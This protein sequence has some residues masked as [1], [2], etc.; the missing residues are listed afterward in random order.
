MGQYYKAV[1]LSEDTKKPVAYGESWDFGSGAKLMEHSY[2]SN[3]FVKAVMLFMQKLGGA[4]LVW[5]GDYDEKLID[6][7]N[8]LYEFVCDNEKNLICI[9]EPA[10]GDYADKFF[11]EGVN[12][13]CNSDKKIAVSTKNIE[14]DSYGFKINP[15]PLLT[16]Q[17]NGQG[18][19]DYWGTEMDKVGT[20]AGDFIFFASE[21]PEG[22]EM[23]EIPFKEK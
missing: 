13:I 10:E 3:R 2:M 23:V 21:L 20:W 22:Y 8:N 9:D 7:K 16:A 17:G 6:G 15:M 1:I 19:G 11:A 14:P 18:G 5:A 12:F 4:R